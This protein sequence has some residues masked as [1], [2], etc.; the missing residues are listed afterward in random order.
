M[1]QLELVDFDGVEY[2]PSLDRDRLTG[3]LLDVFDFMSDQ[4][5]HTLRDIEEGTGHTTASISAQLRNL[6]KLRYGSHVVERK[7]SQF[8]ESGLYFYRLNAGGR[9]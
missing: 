9:D 3:Q 2:K 8:K 1:T 4:D 7:R 5:W 6:R